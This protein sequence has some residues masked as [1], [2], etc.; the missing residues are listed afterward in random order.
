LG[1][2]IKI[3]IFGKAADETKVRPIKSTLG[4]AC[5][6]V[7][8][9]MGAGPFFSSTAL[10]GKAA[11]KSAT[12][13]SDSGEPDL[14]P[15][16]Q[17]REKALDGDY[18]A[19]APL[20]EKALTQDPNSPGLN[21][22]L[23]EVYLRLSNLDRAEVLGLKSVE[24]DPNNAEF[25]MTLGGILASEKKYTEA[26]EQY[27]KVLEL[28][29][30]NQRVPLLLGILEAESGK[31]EEGIKVLTKTIESSPDNFM[32]YFYRAKVYLEMEDVP[33]AKADLEKC[34]AI[35][36]AF[37]EAGTALGTL[38]ER[39][40]E[41]DNAIAAYSKIQGSGDFQKRLAQLY[42][43]KNEFDKALDAFLEYEQVEPD[44]YT[45]KVKIGLI[46]FE[47][48]KYDEAIGR[49]RT[50]LKE[51]PEAGNVR[52]YLAVV[53]EE[54]QQTDKAIVEFKKVPVDS[55]FFKEAMLH[56]GFIYKDQD[57]FKEGIEF[58]KN[59]LAKHKDMVE[60][61]D[62]YASF[63]EAKKNYKQAIGIIQDGLKRF[64][65]DE[66]LLYFEGALDDKVGN[67]E[68]S[69]SEMKKILDINANNAHALNFLGYTYAEMGKNL[70]EAQTLVE[71]ALTLRPDDGYI[72]DSLG[73][74]YFKKGKV[75]QAID[76]LNKAAT[77]ETSE[78]V[79]Y[80]H[81]GDV[82]LSKKDFTKAKEM[83]KKA[84]QL[85]T[86]K[87][88]SDMAKKVQAK[89]SSVEEKQRTPTEAN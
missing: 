52:F 54:M 43:S 42:L 79:I 16:M 80:E 57:K 37:V 20:F 62:M 12:T 36:P 10:A 35:H 22:E 71:K 18:D 74:V 33:K 70:D 63:Y 14:L 58:S 30:T 2:F 41:V 47:L 88:D 3:K 7:L 61:Y 17:A 27:N 69:I 76:Q 72:E 87:K 53:L 73:W 45:V 77:I 38:Y 56:I 11:G 34:L 51:Q 85:S 59:T 5:F 78:P 89:I 31:L 25:H 66:K 68:A 9:L 86:Q 83:Y 28:D 64:P 75:D 6:L 32:A 15:Y 40:N 1:C 82:Y 55:S 81:L 84:Q 50:I 24:L 21:H 65:K 48:K 23:A 49:F 29:P 8:G 67:R 46:Y 13:S 60:F 39:L 44:D 4:W 26:K 19:A